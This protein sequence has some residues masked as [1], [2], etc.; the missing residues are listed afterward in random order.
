MYQ[1][2]AEAPNGSLMM[3]LIEDHELPTAQMPFAQAALNTAG[4]P[5]EFMHRAVQAI[6][7][8]SLY[9]YAMVCVASAE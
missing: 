5:E 7:D 3:W 8:F 2:Y 1:A 6:D 4:I 9:P